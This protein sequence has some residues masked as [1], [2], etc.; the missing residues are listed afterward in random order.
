MSH[1]DFEADGFLQDLAGIGG[2]GDRSLLLIARCRVDAYQDNLFDRYSIEFPQMLTKSACKRK[3]QFLAGRV[4]SRLAISRLGG[5][6]GDV[7]VGH[8][9]QPLWPTGFRGSISHRHEHVAGLATCNTDFYSGVDIEEVC[10]E[11]RSRAVAA[12]AFV[13]QERRFLRSFPHDPDLL[14]TLLFSAK[15]TLFKAL[16]PSVGRYFRLTDMVVCS[17]NIAERTLFLEL[18]R[19]FNE[20]LPRKTRF[21]IDFLFRATNVVTWTNGAPKR[22]R[23]HGAALVE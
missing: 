18:A 5:Q 2:L 22:F 7:R 19:D 13:E 3:A 4:L 10:T 15:E 14:T 8:A 16:F 1:H 11:R 17:L 12:I 9:R 21:R 20:R 23:H 6:S